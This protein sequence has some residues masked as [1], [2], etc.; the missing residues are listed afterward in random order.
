MI[1]QQCKP[2][3]DKVMDA[4]TSTEGSK[5]SSDPPESYT[6]KDV[7]N[8]SQNGTAAQAGTINGRLLHVCH[9][10]HYYVESL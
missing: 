3:A 2:G 6:A 10:N 7:P 9:T 4:S 5:L 1:E 8:N